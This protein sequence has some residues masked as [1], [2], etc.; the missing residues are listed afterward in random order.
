MFR[1]MITLRDILVINVQGVQDV[2]ELIVA[3]LSFGA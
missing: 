2:V 1:P 3:C